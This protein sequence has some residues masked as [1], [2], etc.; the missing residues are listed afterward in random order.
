M[1]GI[2][3]QHRTPADIYCTSCVRVLCPECTAEHQDAGHRLLPLAEAA[4][5]TRQANSVG[6]LVAGLNDAV[7]QLQAREAAVDFEVGMAITMIEAKAEKAKQAARAEGQRRK[8]LFKQSAAALSDQLESLAS[9]Q[10]LVQDS[11]LVRSAVESLANC[12]MSSEL[13]ST[14]RS[15]SHDGYSVYEDHN[16]NVAA[17]MD[18]NRSTA[19]GHTSRR[20]SDENQHPCLNSP[21]KSRWSPDSKKPSA[22]VSPTKARALGKPPTSPQKPRSPVKQRGPAPGVTVRNRSPSRSDA[23]RMRT[24]P[25]VRLQSPLPGPSPRLHGAPSDESNAGSL[26]IDAVQLSRPNTRSRSPAVR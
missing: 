24:P 19:C 8:D 1:D 21:P 25:G 17:A 15:D 18:T 11:A 6:P 10:D 5:E 22:S 13:G 4:A 23:S 9:V 7:R 20:T 12:K 3:D 2:C 14:F 16:A 26:P